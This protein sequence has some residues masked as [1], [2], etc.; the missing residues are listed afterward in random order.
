MK[1]DSDNN[2]IATTKTDSEQNKKLPNAE[3]TYCVL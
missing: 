1:K 3:I 2:K